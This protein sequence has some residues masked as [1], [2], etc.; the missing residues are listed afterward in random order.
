[1]TS[2]PKGADM[3]KHGLRK[4]AAALVLAGVITVMAASS[5][6]AQTQT[7]V[8]NNGYSASAGAQVGI[9]V[10]NHKMTLNGITASAMWKNEYY[11]PGRFDNGQYVR[12]NVLSRVDN[13]GWTPLYGLSN[14]IL[15]KTVFRPGGFDRDPL[16]FFPVS[17][18]SGRD[19]VIY[20]Q[21]GH[22]YQV[23]VQVSWS[24]GGSTTTYANVVPTYNLYQGGYWTYPSSAAF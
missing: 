11:T 16:Y 22:T 13:G 5:A 2:L 24:T 1:M 21:H 10:V 19:M 23:L 4:V 8:F 3:K 14:W 20:G 9:D 6:F 12:Y 15:V 7:Y 17:T 18:I